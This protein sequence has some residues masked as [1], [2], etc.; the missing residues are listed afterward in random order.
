MPAST[1]GYPVRPSRQ[2][3]SPSSSSRQA[4]A[5]GRRSSWAVSG[6]AASS[7]WLKSRQQSWRTNASEPSRSSERATTSPAE[8]QPKWR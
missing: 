1:S 8:T 6:F 2:A 3:A 5:R 4:A 7:W